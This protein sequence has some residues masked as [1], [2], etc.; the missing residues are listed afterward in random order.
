MSI[1]HRFPGG[2]HPHEGK[3]GKAATAGLP[4]V[5]APLPSR[6]TIPLQQHIGAPC[7]PLVQK[8][9]YVKVGQMIGEPVGFVSAAVHA[10]VSGTVVDVMPCI[11]ANGT[12]V[13]AVVIDNDHTDTWEDLTPVQN[14]EAITAQE[15]SELCRKLGIVGMGG[16]TFPTSV[17]LAVP[18]DKK[19]D[20]LLINGAECEP[21]LSADHRLMAEKAEGIVCGVRLVKKALNIPTVKIGVELN[22]PDAIDALKACIKAD[23]GIEVI[24]LKVNYPQGGEKQLTY[25]L[26]G[27][28]VRTGGLPLDIGVIVMN[29]GTCYAIYRAVYEGRPVIDRVVTVGGTVAKPANYLARIGSPVE[30]LLDTS[31]G[32]LPETRMLIYGGPMMGM[33]ISRHDIPV[34]KGCSGVLALDKLAALA[35]EGACIRCGRC[36]EACPMLLSPT[37]LDKYMRKGMYEEAEQAGALNCME[38]GACTWSCPARRNLTQSCRVLKKVITQRKK[39][40]AAL[41]GG[42]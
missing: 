25:A 3:G 28:K 37:M 14:P 4:I 7:K 9:D 38:C 23:D 31:E 29:V 30:W 11:V 35:E 39:E 19:V 10:S 26:T 16:A 42:K 5:E 24:G 1:I 15:L 34:T 20:T 27:R 40:E 6:V 41:K 33:A 8:G 36:V 32:M 12:Q 21:Y 22:K 2:I 17:K 13:N 18:A